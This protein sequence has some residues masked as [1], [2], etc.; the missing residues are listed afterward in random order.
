MMLLRLSDAGYRYPGTDQWIFRHLT[1]E[2][3]AGD[4][5][6]LTGRN[7][8]GKTTLLK[9]LAGLLRVTE[10]HI[11]IAGPQ[12]VA[13]M[14][15]SAKDM[16]APNLTVAEHLR[17]VRPPTRFSRHDLV[18]L[19]NR[20][21]IGLRERAAD[22]VGHL[23]GGQRQVV[24]L[25][26]TLLNGAAILCL[27]EFTASMDERSSVAASQIVRDTLATGVT[28]VVVVS[29]TTLVTPVTRTLTLGSEVN[30]GRPT[31]YY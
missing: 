29:H 9:V 23:S 31:T 27:D 4:A 22:F 11:D 16:L 5:I 15:Q 20:F 1:L 2:I 24:A 17:L 30:N 25:I 10:G 19:L 7:G 26:A 8:A 6:H 13:Y 14:D 3:N 28:A 21:D 18:G 12:A